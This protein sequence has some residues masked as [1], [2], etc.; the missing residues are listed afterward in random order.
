MFHFNEKLGFIAVEKPVP[1]IGIAFYLI[2][3]LLP[4]LITWIATNFRKVLRE[5]VVFQTPFFSVF[6]VKVADY[7]DVE[8]AIQPKLD[9][10]YFSNAQDK[11]ELKI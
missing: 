1:L 9:P 10:D 4:I 8:L 6:N 5:G 7:V 3:L 11:P 2:L